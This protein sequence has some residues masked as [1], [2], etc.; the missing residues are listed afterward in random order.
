MALVLLTG[1]H[2]KTLPKSSLKA[3]DLA[4]WSSA[5]E[6]SNL[7]ESFYGLSAVLRNTG[8]LSVTLKA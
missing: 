5:K 4:N 1:F 8:T 6:G 7:F 3:D 2:V